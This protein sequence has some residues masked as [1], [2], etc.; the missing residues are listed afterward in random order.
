MMRGAWMA[1][2]LMSATTAAADIVGSDQQPATGGSVLRQEVVVPAS[3]RDVWQ[4]LT[5]ASGWQ[6]WAVPFAHVDLRID[7]LIETSYDPAARRGDPGNIHNRILSFLPER[8]LSIQ[9]VKAPPGFVHADKLSRLHSVIEIEAVDAEQT[10]VAIS[11]V[12]YGAEDSELA[13]F[14]RQG[15]DWTL[16]RLVERF[17]SGPVDWTEVR[18]PRP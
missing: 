16:S 11:G 17:A 4:A 15:N 13:E 1:W 5:T 7:G 8:M 2:L 9:A 6:S 3:L 10:R 14:F 12:G 18:P